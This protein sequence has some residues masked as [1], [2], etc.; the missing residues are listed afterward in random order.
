MQYAKRLTYGYKAGDSGG[1]RLSFSLLEGLIAVFFCLL[2]LQTGAEAKDACLI[3]HEPL[4]KEKVVHAAVQMGCP[5]CHT[6]IDAKDIPH[7]K[8]GKVS[9]G[10]SADQPGLCFGC[11]DKAKFAKANVHAAVGMGCTS[12]H[13][14]HS[15]KYPK[16][17]SSELPDLCYGCHDKTKFTG[18]TV[19]APVGI[20]MCTS[21]HDPHA[22][23][24]AKLLTAEPP[25][26]CFSCH[27]KK[28]FSAKYM[29]APAAGGMCLACHK[30]HASDN[31]VLL[32]KEPID[33]CIECHAEVR[34]KPHAVTGFSPLGG[35][36]LGEPRRMKQSKERKYLDDPSRPGRRFYCGSCHFPH[37]S[38][39]A[40]LLRAS[41][42]GLCQI[43]H[44]K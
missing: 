24:S 29:H 30:P 21:C 3:C 37:S 31:P 7:N 42:F 35:H 11:H 5:T 20:G 2:F 4:V 27:D 38:D 33:S 26:L 23:K 15:S 39:Y 6:S 34:K 25:D 10:L 1:L 40:K 22:S 41:D 14:P 32:R 12:C 43:C 28:G 9:K 36:P 17:L 13:N 16:L 19:H 44:K 18:K 8:T